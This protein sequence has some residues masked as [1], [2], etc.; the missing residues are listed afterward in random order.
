M[1]AAQCT[2]GFT[3]LAD[4]EMSD[5]L[6]LV[7]EPHDSKGNDD[8]IHEERERLECACGLAAITSE[9]LDAH[10]LT[11]FTPHDATG[12]DGHRHAPA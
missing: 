6:L 2:C 12:T 3:E 4:E 8:L 10:L 9:E 5:H 1:I 11:A 7:F